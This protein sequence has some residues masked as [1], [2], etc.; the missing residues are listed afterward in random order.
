LLDFVSPKQEEPVG[1]R[2]AAESRAAFVPAITPEPPA[3]R[4]LAIDAGIAALGAPD[5]A[6]MSYSPL[7]RVTVT[8]L[9]PI[10]LRLGGAWFGSEAVVRGQHGEG[11]V[12]QSVVLLDAVMRLASY[13]SARATLSLGAG[14]YRVSIAGTATPPY[15]DARDSSIALALCAGLGVELSL[16]ERTDI[17]LDLQALARSPA[18]E[19]NLGDEGVAHLGRPALLMTASVREWW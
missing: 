6:L 7:L 8:V 14:I 5:F 11:R 18:A 17:G 4:S 1:Q 9:D 16:S 13:R 3:P 2:P 12:G 19:V 15:L 10:R